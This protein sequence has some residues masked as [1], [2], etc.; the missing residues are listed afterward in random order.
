MG[1]EII[2]YVL[3]EAHVIE[4]GP[5]RFTLIVRT[6]LSLEL[7]SHVEFLPAIVL[8]YEEYSNL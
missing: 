4:V 6:A 3:R 7:R 2:R 5:F 8:V 1:N